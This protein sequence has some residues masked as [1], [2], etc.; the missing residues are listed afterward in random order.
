MRRVHTARIH[1]SPEHISRGLPTFARTA[2]PAWL[3]PARPRE[4][5]GWTLLCEFDS[6]PSEQGSPSLA[7]VE[8]GMDAAPHDRLTPGASLQLFERATLKLARVEILD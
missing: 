4:D 1:W 5:E 2:D 7:R 6:P 8:F 3:S